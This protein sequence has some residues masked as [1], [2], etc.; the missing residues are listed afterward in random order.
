MS[1]TQ[2]MDCVTRGFEAAGVIVLDGVRPWRRWQLGRKK[3]AP[4]ELEPGG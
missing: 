1:F 4:G 2:V 3:P